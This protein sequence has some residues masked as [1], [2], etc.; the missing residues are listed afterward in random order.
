MTRLLDWLADRMCR[1]ACRC[2]GHDWTFIERGDVGEL[3]AVCN[4]CGARRLGW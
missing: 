3:W 1:V 4:S 2:W